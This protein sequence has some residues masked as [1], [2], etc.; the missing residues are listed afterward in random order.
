VL[1]EGLTTSRRKK[2]KHEMLHTAPKK[3]DS[4]EHGNEPPELYSM[5]FEYSKNIIVLKLVKLKNERNMLRFNY[6]FRCTSIHTEQTKTWF[7]QNV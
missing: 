2:K 4:C 1:G 3:A 7:S 5:E 6:I